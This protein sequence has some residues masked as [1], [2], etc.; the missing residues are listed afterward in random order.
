MT[1][2]ALRSIRAVFT[3]ALVVAF[4]T[5]LFGCASLGPAT[6]VAVRDV[7]SITGTWKG[8][9]YRSGFEPDSVTLMQ[10]GCL[11]QDASWIIP[12]FLL[13]LG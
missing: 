6:P 3:G 5:L 1:Q 11:L 13:D 9:V 4:A 7:K 10:F 12:I 2:S 8:I